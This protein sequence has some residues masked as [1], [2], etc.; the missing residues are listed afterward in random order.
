LP[1]L[2][3]VPIPEGEPWGA[4]TLTVG[5][6]VCIAAEHVQTA[7]LI[8]RRG[9]QVRTVPLSEFMKAEGGVTCLS[10]LLS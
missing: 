7:E 3:T 9:F 2:E 8:R 4:N 1:E 5:T 6:T 10:L